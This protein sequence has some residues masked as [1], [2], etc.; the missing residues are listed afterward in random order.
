MTEIFI[1]KWLTGELPRSGFV[2]HGLY[3]ALAKPRLACGKHFR[4]ATLGAFQFSR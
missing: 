4:L 2:Q 3:T 1:G